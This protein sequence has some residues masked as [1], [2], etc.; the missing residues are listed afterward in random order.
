MCSKARPRVAA[1]ALQR[2]LE[3]LERW[4][5]GGRTGW[6]G[7]FLMFEACPLCSFPLPALAHPTT[8]VLGVQVKSVAWLLLTHP[9]PP[10]L[11][12]CPC[13]AYLTPCPNYG[14]QNILSNTPIP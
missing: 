12:P 13:S 9:L 8:P 2:R 10:S 1:R 14:S 6:Q 11:C 5:V 7:S 3:E 4:G